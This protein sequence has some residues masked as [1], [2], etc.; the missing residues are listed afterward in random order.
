MQTIVLIMR[1]RPVAQAFMDRLAGNTD[2]SVACERE[3]AR[4]ERVIFEHNA[5]V[6]LIEVA[7][8]GEYGAAYCMALCERLRAA[9]PTCKL[10]LL[11]PEQNEPG[12]L[13]AVRAKRDGRIDDFVFYDASLEYVA[14]KLLSM[15]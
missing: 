14:S 12:V 4:A 10:V 15:L 9:A 2:I 1:R 13:Q 8:S 11:C 5:R 3:Y 6:A 7:E